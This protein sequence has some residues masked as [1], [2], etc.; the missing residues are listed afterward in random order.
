MD[1]TRVPEVS[2]VHSEN[3]NRSDRH[4]PLSTSPPINH[5]HWYS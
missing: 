3:K 5:I 1:K 4:H 2:A